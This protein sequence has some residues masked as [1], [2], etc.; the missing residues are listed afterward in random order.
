M[1][2]LSDRPQVL[3]GFYRGKGRNDGTLI[4]WGRDIDVFVA[5]FTPPHFGR[6]ECCLNLI[7]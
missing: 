4:E 2:E 5:V 3:Y 1:L 6:R 7:F